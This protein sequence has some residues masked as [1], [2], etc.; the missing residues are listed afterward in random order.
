MI[1]RFSRISPV[2]LGTVLAVTYALLSLVFVPFF[3]LFALFM[4]HVAAT[5]VSAG[6][7][8]MFP[9]GF[10]V[11]AIVFPIMYGVL[12]FIFGVI[13]ALIYNLVAGWTGGIE[14]TFS[15]VVPPLPTKSNQILSQL[16]QS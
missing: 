13:G 15:D 4:P 1:K 3:L 9:G 5:G 10:V 7:P 12:G 16:S 14:L 6:Q 8:Q 11:M 2:Q